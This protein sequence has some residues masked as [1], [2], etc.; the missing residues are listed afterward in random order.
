MRATTTSEPQ[1]GDVV[2]VVLVDG[3]EDPI[4][5]PGQ[6]QLHRATRC[7]LYWGAIQS[8]GIAALVLTTTHDDE[9]SEQSGYAIYPL[10]SVLSV[11]VVKRP[12]RKKK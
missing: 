12:R 7:A 8:H 1:R 2:E 3:R 11:K 10:A 9:G 5:D 4:G 6:A